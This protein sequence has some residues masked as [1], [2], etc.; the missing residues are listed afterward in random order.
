M[1]RSRTWIGFALVGVVAAGVGFVARGAV[2]GDE[3]A[4]HEGEK[5]IDGH[6][7][8]KALAGTWTTKAKTNLGDL[9]GK[10][11]YGIMNLTPAAPAYLAKL[12]S[13]LKS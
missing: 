7:L 3:A 12:A 1:K 9:A 2:A 8:V 6:A 4:A 10:V 13:R 5:P 11:T